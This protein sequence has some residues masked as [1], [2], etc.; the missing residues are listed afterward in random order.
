MDFVVR[1]AVHNVPLGKP[2]D[3]AGMGSQIRPT[4]GGIVGVVDIG[5]LRGNSAVEFG[6]IIV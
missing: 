6:A 3:P 1:P 5:K 4:G 2:P